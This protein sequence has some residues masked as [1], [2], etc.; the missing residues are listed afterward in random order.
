MCLQGNAMWGIN[1]QL[2]WWTLGLCFEGF[3]RG[4]GGMGLDRPAPIQHRTGLHVR[5]GVPV[6]GE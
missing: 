6:L 3:V 4:E 5:L 2:G 1:L